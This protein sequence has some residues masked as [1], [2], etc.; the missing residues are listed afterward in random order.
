MI[1]LHMPIQ[2]KEALKSNLALPSE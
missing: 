1:R 2:K